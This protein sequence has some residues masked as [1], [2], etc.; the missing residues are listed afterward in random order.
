[1]TASTPPEPTNRFAV[2][3]ADLDAVHVTQLQ[4][5]ELVGD[6]CQPAESGS[7]AAGAGPEGDGDGD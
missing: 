4:M 6:G 2:P 5:V 1:M 7:A 3:L